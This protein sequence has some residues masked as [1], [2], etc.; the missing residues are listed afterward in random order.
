MSLG[1]L[2]HVALLTLL[3]TLALGGL[4][5]SQPGSSQPVPGGP[6]V[7]PQDRKP[8]IQRIQ[9][10]EQTVKELEG[11]LV[12]VNRHIAAL[13]SKAATH[14]HHVVVPSPGMLHIHGVYEL[15]KDPA[16]HNKNIQLPVFMQGAQNSASVQTSRPE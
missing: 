7:T 1:R 16:S 8:L 4:A 11:K 6:M 2:A 3:V 9:E 14:T 10:L 13:D 15:M 5:R 12:L